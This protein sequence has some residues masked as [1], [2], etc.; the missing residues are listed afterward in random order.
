[1]EVDTIHCCVC[2]EKVKDKDLAP[3][4]IN[5]VCHKECLGKKP[6]NIKTFTQKLY[7]KLY[8]DL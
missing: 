5:F 4:L 7:K 3:G 6:Y 2:G 8:Y 1:M